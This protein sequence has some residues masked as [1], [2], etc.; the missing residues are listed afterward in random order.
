MM[1][2]ALSIPAFGIFQ[3]V[4][5][6]LRGVGET[7]MCLKLTIIINLLYLLASVVTINFMKLDIL[8]TA[9][10]INFARIVGA[11][12]AIWMVFS[13]SAR[14][15]LSVNDLM[16]FDWKMQLNVCKLGVPFA[17]EQIF[18][19]FGSLLCQVYLA[20]L[21]DAVV[22]GNSIA[23]T[24]INLSYAGG[25]AVS[26]LAITVVGQCIGAKEIDLARKYGK[27][28]IKLGTVFIIGGM[29]FLLSILPLLLSIFNPQPETQ[30]YIYTVLFVTMIPMPFIWSYS[31]VT[32]NIL[33]SAGDATYTSLVS[34]VLMWVFRVG[35]GYVL[36][37]PMGYG[38]L[39]VA[40]TTG[41]EWV[42]R[43]IMY[44]A[45]FKGTKWYTNKLV[46]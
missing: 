38:V 31:Y 11:I 27:A 35:V 33:R 34:L 14:I 17:T 19:N 13:G 43:S 1:G 4:F 32:P 25:F 30:G 41:V 29:L 9:I 45:R 22:A 7:K 16:K 39:G 8:G 12:V 5:N 40:I 42:V 3:G 24:L 46:D 6:V 21:G 18:I 20:V 10:S 2:M 15:K 44:T 26:N 23:G 28:M 37:I 36:A